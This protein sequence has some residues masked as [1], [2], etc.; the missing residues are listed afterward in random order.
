MKH[1]GTLVCEADPQEVVFSLEG[2]EFAFEL[3]D[4]FVVGKPS[5]MLQHMETSVMIIDNKICHWTTHASCPRSTRRER[6]GINL[7]HT[8]VGGI[9]R[10]LLLIQLIV[11]EIL[12]SRRLAAPK[13]EACTDPPQRE[14]GSHN[15]VE[16]VKE[17]TGTRVLPLRPRQP[18]SHKQFIIITTHTSFQ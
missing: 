16:T 18:A 13:R 9:F 3:P 11:V 2:S 6:R 4:P 12:I 14:V 15:S 7:Q 10:G 17:A 1:R 5:D 8:A